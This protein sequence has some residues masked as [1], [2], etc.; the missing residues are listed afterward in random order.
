MSLLIILI[1]AWGAGSLVLARLPLADPVVA[2]CFRLLAGLAVAA[3][4][5]LAV[6]SVSLM[7]AWSALTALAALTVLRSL[8]IPSTGPGW[9]DA[10]AGLSPIEK[11]AIAAMLS[12]WVL[13]LLGALA[14]AT[15]WDG[16]VAHL[17][18]P[19]AYDRLGHIAIQPGN[20]YSGY[21]HAVHALYAVAYLG[22]RELPA[23]LLNWTFGALACGAVYSLGRQ[24]GTRQTG[25]VAAAILATAPVFMD[26]AGNISIDLAFVAFSTAALAAAFAWAARGETGWIALAGALAGASCGVRHTGYLVCLLLALGIGALTLYRR[27]DRG[28]TLLCFC[29]VTILAASPWL[30]RSWL[31]TGNP[32]FPMLLSWFPPAPIDHIAVSAPG[33]HES[34]AGSTGLG[35]LPLLR[36]P[37][38]II[39]RP[40]LFDG[41]NKSPGGL[42]LIL[43]VPGL[44]L[45]GARAW[46]LG[47]FSAAG[48]FAF[49]YFQRL[50][51]Y[52][53]PFFTPMMVV[54][55]LAVER[56]TRGRW[57]V[58][59]ALFGAFAYGLVLHAAAIHFKIPVLLGRETRAEYLRERVERFEAFE[60]ANRTLAGGTVLTLDQRSYYLYMP[61]F[62]NHWSLK[63]IAT[64]PLEAQLRWLKE[65]GIRYVMVPEDF[66]KHSGALSGE[67]AA[68][69]DSWS[70]TPAHFAL[71][72]P[73]LQLPRRNGGGVEQVAFYEVR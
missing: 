52:L 33:I 53:L 67:I 34:I 20:V 10:F 66:I 7:A 21:P 25:L 38:D 72:A 28:V 19:A 26:Q 14:P 29:A 48:G 64:E 8:R 3:L 70:R 54:A 55:A 27:N 5:A 32:F 12:A 57:I 47:G 30:F 44:V 16:A 23:S 9:T 40:A 50:A 42:V 15:G 11:G 59:A 62:Q 6:G 17:A 65:Q 71:V 35:L 51:R 2:C 37:W 36:F 13:T 31:V 46:W 41:W 49:F 4:I 73:P 58:L 45:G 69:I 56:F 1:A 24:I 60:F 63:R 43:G 22:Q 68:M 61:T 39:M 18:L